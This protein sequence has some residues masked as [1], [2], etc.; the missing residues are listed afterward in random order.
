MICQFLLTDEIITSAGILAIGGSSASNACHTG[1]TAAV[2]YV[3]TA[4]CN[5]LTT[6]SS[7]IDLDEPDT[8]VSIHTDCVALDCLAA[9]DDSGGGFTSTVSFPTVSG[10]TYYI[11]WDD[12]W[13]NGEF[14]FEISC[15]GAV[16]IDDLEEN[17]LG[18]TIYPNPAKDIF[19]IKDHQ[20]R[21]R[22][23]YE[24][25]NVF[26]DLILMGAS[27]SNQEVNVN[28]LSSG[29]YYLKVLENGTLIGTYKI[30]KE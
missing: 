17:I 23:Q 11:E 5:G 25:Y 20:N 12:R 8:R 24:I 4:T 29:M 14:D 2:W 1:S 9:N 10:Q 16:G 7:S 19:F 18:F 22:L 13:D 28:H 27:S 15:Q 30:M 26:G 21:S 3:Y 6:V